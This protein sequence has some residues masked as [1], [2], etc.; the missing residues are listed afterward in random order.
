MIT[1]KHVKIA[2]KVHEGLKLSYMIDEGIAE[3][4][5]RQFIVKGDNDVLLLHNPSFRR[6]RDVS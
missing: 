5:G 6:L 2:Q 4:H 3:D 1:L